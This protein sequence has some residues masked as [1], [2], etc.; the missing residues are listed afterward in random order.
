MAVPRP[1]ATPRRTVDKSYKLP[2]PRTVQRGRSHAKGGL[3]PRRSAGAC[4]LLQRCPRCEHSGLDFWLPLHQ[5]KGRR[6]I[7][8]KGQ[9]STLDCRVP[10][11]V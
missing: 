8:W 3:F 1:C 11:H 9:P 2:Q 4:K 10:I 6:L 5:G 7:T